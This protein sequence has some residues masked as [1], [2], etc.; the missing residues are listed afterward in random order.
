MI[1]MQTDPSKLLRQQAKVM[2]QTKN[3]EFYCGNS[4]SFEAIE[5]VAEPL[6]CIKPGPSVTS[7]ASS[8]L[9]SIE[10]VLCRLREWSAVRGEWLTSG[11]SRKMVSCV[12]SCFCCCM[13]IRFNSMCLFIFPTTCP[14]AHIARYGS[15][16]L[17]FVFWRS[18]MVPTNVV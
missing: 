12:S 4:S 5:A 16:I 13:D 10:P 14:L 9:W 11:V 7:V 15:G 18:L 6:S 1:K 8:V 2:E 3:P 17:I